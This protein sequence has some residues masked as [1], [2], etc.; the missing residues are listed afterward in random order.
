MLTFSQE[1]NRFSEQSKLNFY[2][3]LLQKLSV[4][5]PISDKEK[6]IISILIKNIRVFFLNHYQDL[7]KVCELLQH[8][9]TEHKDELSEPAATLLQ[10]AIQCLKKDF[11]SSRSKTN[12]N[13]QTLSCLLARR[14]E[15]ELAIQFLLHPTSQMLQVINIISRNIIQ[16][17]VDEDVIT[18][19]KEP[20]ADFLD[21]L[22][23]DPGD[24]KQPFYS[25]SFGRYDHRP[26]MSEVIATLNAGQ[27]LAKVLLIH[28]MLMRNAN[29]I[30]YD[31]MID[32]VNRRLHRGDFANF[33]R[34]QIPPGFFLDS[35]VFFSSYTQCCPHLYT[36]RGRKAFIEILSHQLGI[37][38]FAQD[39][40]DL[41]K[42]AETWHPDVY[43]YIPN[44]HSAYLRRLLTNDIPYVSGPSGMVSLLL[45]TM[46]FFWRR[47]NTRATTSLYFSDHGLYC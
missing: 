31:K 6:N 2:G 25:F 34:Q 12:L 27:P 40:S 37:M 30:I 41:P 39:S 5:Q 10:E 11:L 33:V 35:R 32:A 38:R 24:E 46:T 29:E 20:L 19:F 18:D 26:S 22:G 36:D 43:C 3:L 14:F 17:L 9:I 4:L 1:L 28:F 15:S 21:G 44:M 23:P 16:Q 13:N 7:T 47:F 42:L 45:G 8:V